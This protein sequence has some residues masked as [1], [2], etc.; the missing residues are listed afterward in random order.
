MAYRT[1]L[2]I[3]C[4]YAGCTKRATDKV[5][6]RFHDEVGKFCATHAIAKVHVLEGYEREKDVR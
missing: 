5:Y 4:H 1:K 2:T 6:T 3:L